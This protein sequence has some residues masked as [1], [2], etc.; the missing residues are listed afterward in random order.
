MLTEV[1]VLVSLEEVTTEAAVVAVV[2]E[3]LEEV[4]T[5]EVIT[6][7][8]SISLEVAGRSLVEVEI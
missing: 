5:G 8:V 7:V 1:V 2:S 6:V 3:I 4:M